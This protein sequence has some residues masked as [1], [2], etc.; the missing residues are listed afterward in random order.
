MTKDCF[1]HRFDVRVAGGAWGRVSSIQARF[2]HLGASWMAR[3]VFPNRD[4]SVS[5][6][7][8]DPVNLYQPESRS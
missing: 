5:V 7:T 1:G 4:A 2:R 8:P 3:R 6:A